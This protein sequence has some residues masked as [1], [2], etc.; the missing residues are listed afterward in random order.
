[1]K[2]SEQPEYQV[3]S[4]MKGRCL[5]KNN[6]KYPDYGGRGIT[7]CERWTEKGK[8]YMN[9]IED[10]GY[11]PSDKHSIERIDVNGNY[12]PSNCTWI[13]ISDQAWNKRDS[14]D[15]KVGDTFGKLTVLYETEG[16]IR[17][18]NENSIRRYFKVKCVCG[19]EK[20]IR[21]DKLRQR[22]NQ[23]CGNRS[24]NKFAPIE[25]L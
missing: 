18:T 21:M 2:V 25:S 6:K 3:W 20:D 19:S 24:C 1:M 17:P 11:R 14:A 10:L 8:G 12:E 22:K 15:V 5:N 9:F 4:Q 7:V 13:L 23:S 16:K